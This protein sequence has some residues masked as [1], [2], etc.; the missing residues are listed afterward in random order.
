M[1]GFAEVEL[2]DVKVHETVRLPID[3]AT[4]TGNDAASHRLDVVLSRLRYEPARRDRLDEE[5]ALDRRFVL[6]DARDAAITG[7]ARIDPNA[8]DTLLDSLLGTTG[9]GAVYSASGHL[10]G[11]L[12]ARA[13]SRVRRGPDDRVDR[14]VRRVGGAVRGGRAA[15]HR[16]RSIS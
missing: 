10:A 14:A 1:V 12:D 7:T 9:P 16:C 2:G 3:L 4:R 13:S 11:D 6:P 5:L 15:R 8:N